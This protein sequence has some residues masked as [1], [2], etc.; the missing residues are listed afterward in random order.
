MCIRCTPVSLN[1]YPPQ[2]SVDILLTS[3][4]LASGSYG[5]VSLVQ[6]TRLAKEQ[7]GEDLPETVI[8]KKTVMIEMYPH[9]KALVY[10]EVE[11]MKQLDLSH[12]V[13]CW[14]L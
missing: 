12:A 8:E 9:E 1:L 14:C 5:V 4:K 2:I 13:K 10:N 11:I 6:P 3:V 7:I